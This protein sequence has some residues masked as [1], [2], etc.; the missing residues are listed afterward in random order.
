MSW[1]DSYCDLQLSRTTEGHFPLLPYMN[2]VE[3]LRASSG[4]IWA[5]YLQ[6]LCLKWVRL[7]AIVS[8]CYIIIACK[9]LYSDNFK[10]LRKGCGIY[11]KMEKPPMHMDSYNKH[12]FVKKTILLKHIHRLNAVTISIPMTFFTEQVVL[13]L[14]CLGVIS[15]SV[16]Q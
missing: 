4:F 7:S 1:N 2:P 13:M 6:S 3:I 9:G 10:S 12:S 15:W 8:D 11:K 14:L 5:W 16:S